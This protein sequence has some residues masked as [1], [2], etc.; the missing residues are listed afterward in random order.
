[1][2][3]M[4]SKLFTS[5]TTATSLREEDAVPEKRQI[6][7]GKIDLS[8]P[9]IR[10]QVRYSGITEETLG[11]VASWREEAKARGDILVDRF[12]AHIEDFH[13]TEKILNS[14]TSVEAQRPKLKRYFES[15]FAGRIDDGYL[16]GRAHIGR[17][18]DAAGLGPLY[19]TAMHRF[20][21]HEFTT[22]LLESNAEREEMARALDAFNSLLMFD[23]ALIVGAYADARLAEAE[24]LVEDLK[25]DM[26]GVGEQ[27]KELLQLSEQLAAASEQ[28]LAATQEMST[29]ARSI[30][31]DANAANEVSAQMISVA[32][33]GQDDIH[34]L[35]DR[36]EKADGAMTEV[37]SE[38]DDLTSNAR[39]IESFVTVIGSIADQTNLL[40]LNAAIEAARAG[41]AGRGFAVVAAEVKTLAESTSESLTN[42]SELVAKT[43]RSVESVA[44]AIDTARGEVASSVGS[45]T[46]VTGR[47]K[48][49]VGTVTSM[50]ERFTSIAAAIN[51]LAS[52]THD[53]EES[54][55]FIA[56]MAS[57]TSEL[58]NS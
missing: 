52:N 16:V 39:E 55:G 18:H 44:S 19:Y 57:R 8:M 22:A 25:Q 20:F 33:S 37:S 31:D 43:E 12:Y 53:I 6:Q 11:I 15:L 9:A 10:E 42:I 34:V 41:E 24:N 35:V 32:D 30:T 58:A 46:T 27:Q 48:E 40:A 14:R 13:I 26:A 49:I 5:R 23:T 38:L 17:L 51:A 45:S 29:G 28:A 7:P 47:F 54:A 2:G 56:D 3:I 21:M 36:I 1:M 4:F 50:T